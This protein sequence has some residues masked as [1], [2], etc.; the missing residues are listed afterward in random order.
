MLDSSFEINLWDIAVA[1]IAFFMP[2][3][4]GAALTVGAHLF[5][6]RRHQVGPR[7]LWVGAITTVA[8]YAGYLVLAGVLV[9]SDGSALADYLFFGCLLVE[10]AVI[11]GVAYRYWKSLVITEG[12]QTPD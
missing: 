1:F 7:I 3:W 4:Y 5:V 9:T 11:V 6:Q 12:L 10:T 2:I 8:S